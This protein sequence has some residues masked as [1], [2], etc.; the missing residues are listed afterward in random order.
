MEKS[1]NAE[2]E[3]QGFA[4]RFYTD[5]HLFARPEAR[6]L[7]HK[8]GDHPRARTVYWTNAVG[9]IAMQ[10]LEEGEEG[11]RGNRVHWPLWALGE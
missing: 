3:A 2:L 5:L 8:L 1:S 7:M 6:R 10:S 11:P 4:P 9:D